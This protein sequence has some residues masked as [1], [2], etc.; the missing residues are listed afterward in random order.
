MNKIIIVDDEKIKRIK[1]ARA[2]RSKGF[3]VDE[4][5]NGIDAI[6][7]IKNTR[8]DLILIDNIMPKLT[9]IDTCKYIKDNKLA[10]GI[11]M[12][13]LIGYGSLADYPEIKEIGIQKAL[14][15]PVNTSDLFNSIAELFGN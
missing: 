5:K 10:P 12:I 8:Y 1:L 14:Q 6:G 9:G 2:L 7:M 3:I 11:K 4:A 15:K 13:L